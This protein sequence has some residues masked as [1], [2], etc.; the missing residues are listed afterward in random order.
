MTLVALANALLGDRDGRSAFT[1]TRACR[2]PSCCCRSGC[3]ATS[4]TIQP[5]PLDEMRVAGARRRRR[6]CAATARR[7]PRSRTRSSCRTATTSTS[8]TNAG[9]GA[10]FW[11]GLPVTQ[12]RRDATRDAGGQFIYLRDVRSG[13]VW[14]ATYQP[15][16]RE[17]DDYLVDVLA[18][19]ARRFRRRD[20]DI[21]TQLDVAVSTEDDVEVRRRD[22]CATRARASARSTSPATRRSS[23]RRRPTISRIRRSASCSSRPNTWPTAPRCSAIAGRAI[24]GDAAAWAFHALSLEGRPQGPVEWETDRARFLGRGR[25]PDD[26]A[27]ARRPR[28]VGHDRRRAR[29]DRQPAPARSGCRRARRCGSRFATG[30]AVGSRDGRGAGAEVPRPERRRRAPSRWRSR[31][32]RA[33]CAIS[34]SRATRRVLFERLASR[35]LGTDGSLRASADDDRAPT[36]SARPGCGRTRISGDLPILLV[37][38]VGD[39]DVR[40]GAPGAAGAGVLAPQGPAAP[41]S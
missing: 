30:M 9:G 2:P 15:T 31:T 16:R 28:A 6:R 24:A 5:R 32:R 17:P 22:A 4:P 1:P 34:A 11:R 38:V 23:W 39:D 41:T 29:S 21:S 12:W 35:V 19:S 13:A 40:A 27:G 14:S 10:S 20:D 36:S 33:A 18:P 25:D 37:R 8:V 7:T 26:P 3:R